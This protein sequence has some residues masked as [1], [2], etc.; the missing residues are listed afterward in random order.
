[1]I[2]LFVRDIC[3]D[4]DVLRGVSRERGEVWY[5]L[6]IEVSRAEITLNR[7]VSRDI[8]RL[9][10]ETVLHEKRISTHLQ[11]R[12]VCLI[13]KF[14]VISNTRTEGVLMLM[15]PYFIHGWHGRIICNGVDSGNI[16]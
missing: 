6:K 4:L 8:T 5:S 14:E 11:F 2:V 16:A 12:K 15:F 10:Q 13:T 1:M 3:P 9:I 7:I